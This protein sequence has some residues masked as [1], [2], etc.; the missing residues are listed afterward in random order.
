MSDS[1][2]EAERRWQEWQ[3]EEEFLSL[4]ALLN[5]G[6]RAIRDKRDLEERLAKAEENAAKW[7]N[8][9]EQGTRTSVGILGDMMAALTTGA[10]TLSDDPEK[11]AQA[12]ALM[13]RRQA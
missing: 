2:Q 9:A 8:L 7:R 1:E 13:E 6:A 5:V 12:V 11:R 10:L 4:V 3:R